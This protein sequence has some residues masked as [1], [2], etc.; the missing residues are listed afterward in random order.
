MLMA[1]TGSVRGISGVKTQADDGGHGQCATGG[2]C[3]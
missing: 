2:A 1:N 3:E